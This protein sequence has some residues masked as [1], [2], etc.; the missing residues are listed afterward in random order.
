MRI[1]LVGGG[2]YSFYHTAIAIE[3]TISPKSPS[4]FYWRKELEAT[5]WALS[6][7]IVVGILLLLSLL[8]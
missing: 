8:N 7:P 3:S 6:V 1:S 4:S 5:I 2:D